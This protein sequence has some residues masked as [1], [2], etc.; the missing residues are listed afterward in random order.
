MHSNL[1]LIECH[2]F[3]ALSLDTDNNSLFLN[4]IPQKHSL[5]ALLIFAQD[6]ILYHLLAFIIFMDLSLEH[7][8]RLP[9]LIWRYNKL[10]LNNGKLI[11]EVQ[12]YLLRIYLLLF[13][14]L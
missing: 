2:I 3:I 14:L 1:L 9:C 13:D 6:Y 11:F 8:I 10:Y 5:S 4:S 12:I 7:V